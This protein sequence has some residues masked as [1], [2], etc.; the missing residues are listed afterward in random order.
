M[1]G[2][3]CCCS[4]A[5]WKG[6]GLVFASIAAVI[7]ITAAI[8][9]CSYLY[10]N[11]L[12]NLVALPFADTKC[13]NWVWQTCHSSIMIPSGTAIFTKSL[14]TFVGFVI[15]LPV[16][17]PLIIAVWYYFDPYGYYLGQMWSMICCCSRISS[18]DV[19][20]G[21]SKMIVYFLYTSWVFASLYASIFLGKM[22]AAS[23]FPG[24]NDYAQ[25]DISIYNLDNYWPEWKHKVQ[26]IGWG[27]VARIVESLPGSKDGFEKCASGGFFVVWVL[28]AGV[29]PG[30]ILLIWWSVKRYRRIYSEID[31]EVY[32]N[33]LS[34]GGITNNESNDII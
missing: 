4:S 12:S 25:Y 1:N 29:L 15:H 9:G 14:N 30:S 32:D 3:A 11:V 24:C 33:N 23:Q 31:R 34:N 10:F 21:E 16:T 2:G 13:D 8:V 5:L 17:L 19:K 7:G 26:R 6:I 18:D 27:Q 22:L 28:I 20:R